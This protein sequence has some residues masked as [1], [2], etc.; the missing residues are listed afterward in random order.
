M[1]SILSI[2]ILLLGP[3][4][5]PNRFVVESFSTFF[6]GIG[7]SSPLTPCCA[8]LSPIL[9][10]IGV[11]GAA[12]TFD[13]GYAPLFR[14]GVTW[15]QTRKDGCSRVLQATP[16]PRIVKL[17][18]VGFLKVVVLVIRWPSAT[19]KNA[20]GAGRTMFPSHGKLSS[21]SAMTAR[22]KRWKGRL[23][24]QR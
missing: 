18:G 7:L 16:Q 20:A 13:R 21:L 8:T 5:A 17:G 22:R 23:K 14:T 24:I 3:Y 12:R 11:N 1:R 15:S 10:F 4:R 6:I 19:S 2:L 9:I